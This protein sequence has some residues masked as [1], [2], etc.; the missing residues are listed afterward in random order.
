[1]RLQRVDKVLV[2]RRD[3]VKIVFLFPRSR[4]YGPGQIVYVPSVIEVD[5]GET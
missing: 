4:K 1:M 5:V 2:E 3:K